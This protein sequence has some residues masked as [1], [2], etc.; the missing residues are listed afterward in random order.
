[1]VN[2]RNDDMMDRNTI[3][4]TGILEQYLLGELSD[5]QRIE[6][7]NL[8]KEDHE[9]REYFGT[10]EDD[11][12]KMAFENAVT[13][14]TFIKENIIQSISGP[15]NEAKDDVIPIKKSTKLPTYLA[16]A[17]GLSI[18]FMV[19]S[20][21]FYLQWQNSQQQLKLVQ[22]QT[23]DLKDHIEL[24]ENNFDETNKW[25]TAINNSNTIQLVLKGNEISP[26]SSAI[27]YV[28]HEEKTVILN[29]QGLA[30]LN[31]DETYQMWA[32]VKGEMIDMG[33]IPSDQNM[34]VMKYIDDAESIN[35]TIEPKGGNDH[36]TVERLISNVLL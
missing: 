29:S 25:Y 9:L 19:S 20:L 8:L 4:E 16:V 31:D 36:P 13:P 6:V 14:P 33:V 26:N 32:D 22:D 17:A 35:I 23:D 18:L 1:M 5:D 28:N 21:W 15:S 3:K 27:T 7:E 24:L 34:M 10:I 11:F 12:E 2:F 30:K